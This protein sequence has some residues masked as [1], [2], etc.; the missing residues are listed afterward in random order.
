MSTQAA[1]VLPSAQARLMEVIVTAV[2]S[3][4]CDIVEL[5]LKP[6]IGSDL[7]VFSPGA[8]IDLHLPNGMV[9]QYSLCNGPA[10]RAVL[11]IGVARAVSGRGGSA[12]V[13]D[14]LG[15]GTSLAVSKPRNNFPLV[16]DASEYLFIAGGI[17]ITPILS[18]LRWCESNRKPWRLLYCV[19]SRGR[20]AYLPEI[21]ALQH[22]HV[23]LHCD[24]EA[25]G[26]RADLGAALASRVSGAHVYCCGPAGLM[27]AVADATRLDAPESVHF[28]WFAHDEK[29]DAAANRS[30]D[31]MLAQSGKTVHV[32]SDKSILEAIEDAGLAVPF[33]CR[34]G[35]CGSCLT[36]V[37][38]GEPEH[39]DQVL[40]ASEQASGKLMLICVSRAKGACIELDL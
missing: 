20:A 5:E 38:S 40:S 6:T 10:D 39:R 23:S 22:G 12:C 13:H 3:K 32:P 27:H 15:V 24:D 8:H 34:D 21:N 11:R 2:H 1:Q 31:V 37:C 19:Q 4:A 9:R 36:T 26:A 29:V 28:E 14:A 7:L 33:G 35:L 30:F 25:G 17:G 18:M 16:S